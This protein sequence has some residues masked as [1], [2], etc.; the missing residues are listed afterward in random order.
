MCITIITTA[1]VL[2]NN[3]S[4]QF[5]WPVVDLSCYH[6]GMWI[7]VL[8]H[9]NNEIINCKEMIFTHLY[10]LWLQYFLA[11]ILCELLRGHN[12]GHLDFERAIRALL[13][14]CLKNSILHQIYINIK[15]ASSQCRSNNCYQRMYADDYTHL[16]KAN[17]YVNFTQSCLSTIG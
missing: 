13:C 1:I 11:K 16:T 15:N 9:Y 10:Q 6:W 3:Y 8:A 17:D 4:P 14:F 5:R 2:I 7:V 12:K